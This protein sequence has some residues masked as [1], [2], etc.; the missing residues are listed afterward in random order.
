MLVAEPVLKSTSLSKAFVS[1]VQ[2]SYIFSFYFGYDKDWQ[3]NHLASRESRRATLR[4]QKQGNRL[5]QA[6]A[7]DDYDF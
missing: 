2:G 1:M 7:S 5:G 6:P 3:E 4:Y